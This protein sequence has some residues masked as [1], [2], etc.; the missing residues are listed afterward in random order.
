[1]KIIPDYP[2]FIPLS[3]E[4]KPLFDRAFKDYPPE[5]SEFTFTNLFSWRQAYGYEVSMLNGLIILRAG[6]GKPAC[7][8]QPIGPGDAAGAVKQILRDLNARFCR[9]S[10]SLSVIFK[11]DN[12]FKVE[13]DR[14]NFDY[15]Y[16]SAGLV[17]L[18]GRQYDGKRNQIKKFR[19][20]YKYD[21]AT[22]KGPDAGQ[23]LELEEAW[24]G[25]K[26]CDMIE[27]LNNERQA[28][29]EIVE[30]FEEF[31]L[32]SGIIKL[33]NRACAVAIA[34]ALN[35]ETLVV[36][37]FKADSDIPGLYQ[38]MLNDFLRSNAGDFKYINLEQDLGVPGLR[39][40]KQSY[41][42]VKMIG[43]YTISLKE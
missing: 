41:H 9:I 8:L 20:G 36:H 29:R 14:N 11:D 37:V 24:C 18:A 10:E 1:M 13:E 5:I 4:D 2:Q 30:H 21:Y 42:P 34:E 35:S 15:L 27:G 17:N 6:S 43:K 26:G 33:E 23:I 38:T 25:I 28:I 19:S 22:I 7:F 3:L 40:S 39:A 32:I 16:L 12:A 31:K